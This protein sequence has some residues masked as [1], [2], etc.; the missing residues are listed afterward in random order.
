MNDPAPIGSSRFF[1]WLSE[2]CAPITNSLETLSGFRIEEMP[3]PMIERASMASATPIDRLSCEQ[4][5]LLTSQKMGLEWLA[6]PVTIFVR[7]FPKACVTFFPGDLSLAALRAFP[8][9]LEIA[10]YN[11]RAIIRVG[12]G[13]MATETRVS[14][15]AFA[16]EIEETIAS[17]VSI[18][19]GHS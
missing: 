17:A 8:Q 7:E 2:K 11:A 3:N 1:R 9:L 14:D 10:P 16:Q 12:F 13:W 4:V 19:R 5:R 18:A 6:D 15:P